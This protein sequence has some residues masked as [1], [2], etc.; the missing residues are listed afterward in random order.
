MH[1]VSVLLKFIRMVRMEVELVYMPTA[2]QVI[3]QKI[4]FSPGLTVADVLQR[5]GIVNH[6]PE[7]LTSALGIFSVPVQL[8]TS[9]RAGDRVEIYRPLLIDPKQKRRQRARV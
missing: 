2:T 8:S 6:H 5:T 1:F 3:R 7:V 9:V 4:P